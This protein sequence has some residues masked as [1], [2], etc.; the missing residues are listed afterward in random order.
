MSWL[1]TFLVIIQTAVALAWANSPPAA[2]TGRRWW[3]ATLL[4]IGSLAIAGTV[5]QA[6]RQMD[7]AAAVAGTTVSPAGPGRASEMSSTH[8]LAEQVKTL[9]ARV[10]ELER[11]HQSRAIAPETADQFAA[12][13]KQF[14]SRRVIVSCIPDDTEAYRYANQLVNLLRAGNWDAMGPEVTD[15]FGDI[16]APGVNLYVNRDDS[17]DT[18]KILLDGFAKFNVPY[19]SRVTPSTAIPDAQT[20]ELFVGAQ[21]SS[22]VSADTSK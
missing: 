4:M 10:K 15:M 18:A 20:V 6:R 14:G 12:Y 16:H 8:D 13:L 19:Q 3:A 7:E 2:A 22:E 11:Q 1:P 5:W 17:S 21:R 9:Q